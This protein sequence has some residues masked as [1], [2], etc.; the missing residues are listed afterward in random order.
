[1]RTDLCSTIKARNDVVSPQTVVS[2]GS[3]FDG[4]HVLQPSKESFFSCRAL[5]LVMNCPVSEAFESLRMV[6]VDKTL[7]FYPKMLMLS[8]SADISRAG[9]SWGSS[10]VSESYHNIIGLTYTTSTQLSIVPTLFA[11]K[12]IST[13]ANCQCLSNRSSVDSELRMTL[14][15]RGYSF[16]MR[17]QSSI[18]R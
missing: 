9:H 7:S 13:I 17:T 14:R 5:P 6:L 3:A 11:P 16:R 12:T 8:E 15:R 1:M 2:T 18:P 10:F 4:C